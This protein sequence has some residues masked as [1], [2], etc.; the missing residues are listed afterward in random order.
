VLMDAPRFANQVETAYQ[1][2]VAACARSNSPESTVPHFHFHF[3]FVIRLLHTIAAIASDTRPRCSG[4]NVAR[5]S[6]ASF[7]PGPQWSFAIPESREN[8]GQARCHAHEISFRFRP[9][10][11]PT[12]VGEGLLSASPRTALTR[13]AH[14]GYPHPQGIQ[15]LCVPVVGESIQGDVDAMMAGQV[16]RPRLP[17]TNPP[18]RIHSQPGSTDSRTAALAAG[19]REAAKA[20][21]G[22]SPSTRPH[23]SSTIG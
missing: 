12:E 5:P 10:I 2:H 17:V 4:R 15:A 19:A 22:T 9:P 16:L 23:N 3:P 11:L 6:A 8:H 20:A 13:Q 14:H 1:C 21:S 7:H 18:A